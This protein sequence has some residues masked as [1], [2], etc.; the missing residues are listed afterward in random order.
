[1]SAIKQAG[2][3]ERWGALWDAHAEDWAR[4]EEQQLPT[5]E[6]A[7][8]RVGLT[9]GQR[10]LEV[11]CG[12]GVF[13]RAAADRGAAVAGID[14]SAALLEIARERVA[15]ADLRRG[16]MQSLPYDDDTFDLVAGFNAFFF[17]Q[18][19]VEALREAGR[20]AKPNAPIVIQVWGDP[21]SCSLE[22]MKAAVFEGAREVPSFW[23]PGTLEDLAAAAGL[24]PGE[25]FEISWA[26][27][28]GD[29]PSLV[30]AMCAAA[31]VAAAAQQA[32]DGSVELAVVRSLAPYRTAGGGYRLD[33]AWHFLIARKLIR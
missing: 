13:L 19:M 25:T 16:D 18:D 9:A 29:E 28:F 3:A 7:I 21:E 17:A 5:Y 32:G 27:T 11:G 8:H 30:R 14:A 23:R 26:Y 2:S 15:E 1:M 12:T 20:V 10:V 4:V 22:A 6:A 24:V 33:N 31:P